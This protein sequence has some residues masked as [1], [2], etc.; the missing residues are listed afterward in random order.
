MI[1]EFD[2]LSHSEIELMHKAP[3]LVCILIAGADDHIDNK[4]IRKAITLTEKKQKRAKSHLLE[5]YKEVGEDFEDKLKI[6]IQGFPVDVEK[7]TPLVIKSLEQIDGV[8]KKVDRN[9]AIEFYRS[10]R[11]IA[12]EI[13]N[14][15]GGVLGLK[16]VGDEEEILMALPMVKDPASY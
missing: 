15:S 1:P 12:K 4:E 8:L 5:F 3:M 13:A 14:S 9:F 11:E 7:R 6:V 2:K 10:L 16:S